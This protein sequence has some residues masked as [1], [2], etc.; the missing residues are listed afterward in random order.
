MK[1]TTSLA[2]LVAL[3]L[4]SCNAPS[5]Q[6][7]AAPM[8]AANRSNL[9]TTALYHETSSSTYKTGNKLLYITAQS[10]LSLRKGTNLKSSKILTIPYGSQVQH[11]SSPEHTTM[12]VAGIVGDM[13]QV[14]Y[15]GAVGFVFSGYLS[16]LAPPLEDESVTDYAQRL[17]NP[18]KKV[19]V[20]KIKHVK[21]DAYGLTTTIA[22]P[23]KSW[24][25]AYLLAQK[26]FHIPKSITIDL[27]DSTKET[28]VNH[29]KREKTKIDE[30]TVGRDGNNRVKDITYSYALRDYKRTVSITKKD[31]HFNIAEVEVSQ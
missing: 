31:V 3:I 23:A 16:T 2:A 26:L 22:L 4:S 28:I 14:N 29:K 8:A 24:G 25:E 7:S 10:G 1:T 5:T 18:N 21:G 9:S 6:E 30:V 15:Q 13:V 19:K 27:T 20:S 17:S 11:I 12:T